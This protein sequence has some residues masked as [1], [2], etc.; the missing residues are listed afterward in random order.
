M[1]ACCSHP[2]TPPPPSHGT[3]PPTHPPTHRPGKLRHGGEGPIDIDPIIPLP[4]RPRQ[5]RGV[6]RRGLDAHVGEV[7]ALCAPCCCCCCCGYSGGGGGLGG[8][9]LGGGGLGGVLGREGPAAAAC[10]VCVYIQQERRD[11]LMHAIPSRFP[12][13]PRHKRRKAPVVGRPVL[14]SYERSQHKT[15]GKRL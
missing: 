12:F 2:A 10:V 11:G 14:S 3:H 1:C 8:M 7:C 4:R 15:D 5:E 9:G 13:S 6:Q